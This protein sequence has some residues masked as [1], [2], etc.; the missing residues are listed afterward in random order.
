MEKYPVMAA[1][2]VKEPK[3]V[4]EEPRALVAILP[5]IFIEAHP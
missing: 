3:S 5:S 2:L 1:I 4:P